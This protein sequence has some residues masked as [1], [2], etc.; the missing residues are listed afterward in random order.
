MW[1]HDGL[2]IS[3]T[4]NQSTYS[5]TVTGECGSI[6][7]SSSSAI[8]FAEDEQFLLCVIGRVRP[9]NQDYL[10]V[11]SAVWCLSIY[12]QRQNDIVNHIAG[13]F[14]L[15]VLNKHN[16]RLNIINDQYVDHLIE[17]NEIIRSLITHR[18][19][20]LVSKLL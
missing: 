20:E 19:N 10:A 9:Y 17:V 2:N 14:L 7:L 12:N 4:S 16:G 5:L 3:K 6:N 18:I 13:F 1:C 15:V 11:D 8:T